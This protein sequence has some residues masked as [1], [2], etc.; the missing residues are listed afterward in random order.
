MTTSTFVFVQGFTT[1]II[2][3]RRIVEWHNVVIQTNSRYRIASTLHDN[4][5]SSNPD[6]DP[7]E[8]EVITDWLW[9]IGYGRLVSFQITGLQFSLL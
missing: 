1:V 8:G 9:S 5:R 3:Q 7:L 2:H 6:F 4:K